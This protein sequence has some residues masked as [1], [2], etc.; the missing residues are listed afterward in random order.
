MS[1]LIPSPVL[2]TWQTGQLVT[3]DW[4]N[5]NIRDVQKFLAH[6]PLTI[7]TRN[8]SQSIATATNTAVQF[9]TEVID[10]DGMFSAPSTDIVV[11]RP[12]VYAIQFESHMQGSTAGSI[13]AAHIAI[14]ASGNW[15][16][17]SN[18]APASSATCLNAAAIAA[19]NVGDR[20]QAYVY[21]NSGGAL[22]AGSAYNAP[23][24]SIRL[25]STAQL[26]IDYAN[27]V[28]GGGTNPKPPPS[29]PPTGH[30]PTNYTKTYSATWSRSYAS[31]GS[32]R[33]DDSA[34]CYQGN[35][36]GYGGNQRSLV[37]FNDTAIRADLAGATNIR[38]KFTFKVNHSYWNSGMGVCVG[39]HNYSAKPSTWA[40][41]VNAMCAPDQKRVYSA[42]AGNS[43]TVDFG[44]G[45]EGWAFQ[46]NV[47]KGMAFGPAPD[48]GLTYYGYMYGAT[49]GG[50]PYLTISYTK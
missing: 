32:T 39:A 6:A 40:T 25:I 26:D 19:L 46:N 28:Q 34:Y 33:W 42:S 18:N 36:P 29:A 13:R 47:I 50:K 1:N 9:D 15:M 22:V 23:R 16:G 2:G 27:P 43:Y 11:Q 30:T 3:A 21:Q 17:S 31:D 8:A 48:T 12:G 35:Y 4:L 45:W 10:V 20:V 37:G 14:N 49:Q 44:V 38:V 5:E 41:G 24:L 7:V